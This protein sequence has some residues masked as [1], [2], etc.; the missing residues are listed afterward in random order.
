MLISDIEEITK[1][2]VGDSKNHHGTDIKPSAI[3]NMRL[4]I[5]FCAKLR[6]KRTTIFE[7]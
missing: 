4:Y 3:L 1:D 2:I 6:Y 5:A 7:R